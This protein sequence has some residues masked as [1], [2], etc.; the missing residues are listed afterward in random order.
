MGVTK[1]SHSKIKSLSHNFMY[2]SP[3]YIYIYISYCSDL[4]VEDGNVTTS[5]KYGTI[6]P[7]FHLPST[8]GSLKTFINPMASSFFFRWNLRSPDCWPRAKR[9]KRASR[10]PSSQAMATRAAVVRGV[11]WLSLSRTSFSWSSTSWWN[12]RF[13]A[14]WGTP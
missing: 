4:G 9:A 11:P 10:G 1:K 12:S 7:N 6:C 14:S 8:S 5:P 2:P 3:M 13:V